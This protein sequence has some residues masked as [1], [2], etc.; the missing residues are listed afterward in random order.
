[1]GHTERLAMA[2]AS[3]PVRRVCVV[4]DDLV[5]G[6]ALRRLL[7]SAGY[8]AAAFGSAEEFLA[9][10]LPAED[11]FLVLDVRMP[12]LD[13]PGLF[14]RLRASGSRLP[15]LFISA[16][17][18]PRLCAEMLALGAVGWLTKP[19]PEDRLLAAIAAWGAAPPPD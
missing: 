9:A 3:A 10:G 14:R 15:V 12:G 13:G 8:E 5:V 1:M 18:N 17:D 16:L 4:D 7:R 6:R 2:P 19:V 11:Q